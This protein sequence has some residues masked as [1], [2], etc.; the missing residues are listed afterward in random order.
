MPMTWW[1]GSVP[2]DDVPA[3]RTLQWPERGWS[4]P[5]HPDE[6]IEADGSSAWKSFANLMDLS[7]MQLARDKGACIVPTLAGGMCSIWE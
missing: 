6:L 3:A 5:G 4:Q 7:M 1:P 2:A